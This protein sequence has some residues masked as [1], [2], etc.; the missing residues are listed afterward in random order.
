[1][2]KIIW[3]EPDIYDLRTIAEYIELNK[4]PIAKNL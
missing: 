4:S 3:T 2:I 1:M